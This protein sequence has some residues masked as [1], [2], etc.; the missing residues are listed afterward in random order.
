MEY[1]F[2][3]YIRSLLRNI[4][5]LFWQKMG[6]IFLKKIKYSEAESYVKLCR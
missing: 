1:R 4:C 5:M 3:K 2:Y 6:E